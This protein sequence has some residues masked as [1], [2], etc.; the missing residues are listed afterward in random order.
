MFNSTTTPEA[1]PVA[2][3]TPS[4][5]GRQRGH[6]MRR[7][8]SRRR[9]ATRLLVLTF[10]VAILGSMLAAAPASAQSPPPILPPPIILPALPPIEAPPIDVPPIVAPPDHRAPPT[11]FNWGIHANGW[12]VCLRNSTDE[13]WKATGYSVFSNIAAMPDT[14]APRKDNCELRGQPSIYGG[15]ANI[16]FAYQVDYY[17]FPLNVRLVSWQPRGT[18]PE[19]NFTCD[20]HAA[21]S[22]APAK[23]RVVL[24]TMEEPIFVIL[25]YDFDE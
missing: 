16:N 4:S 22:R 15:P 5:A 25:E 23:C 20:Y 6:A 14:V 7:H 9:S 10:G 21:F 1:E 13:T 24:G 17:S 12:H 18:S 3:A 2:A 8:L 11:A 19:F